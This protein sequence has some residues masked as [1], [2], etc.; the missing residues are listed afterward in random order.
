M[1]KQKGYKVSRPVVSL[2]Q[3]LTWSIKK[4]SQ[5]QKIN[6]LRSLNAQTPFVMRKPERVLSLSATSLHYSKRVY[7]VPQLDLL[8][9]H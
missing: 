4:W 8:F 6:T 2:E 5:T 3:D 1:N 9:S 7:V